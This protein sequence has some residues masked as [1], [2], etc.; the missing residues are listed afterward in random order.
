MLVAALSL[1]AQPASIR[2][3][4]P[5]L[6]EAGVPFFAITSPAS[7]G[8][9]SPPTDLQPLPDGRILAL[10]DRE[11]AVGDGT[12]WEVFSLAGDDTAPRSS[13]VA[14]AADGQIYTGILSGIA[15]LEFQA[16]GNLHRVPIAHTPNP[17]MLPTTAFKAG[18]RWYWYGGVGEVV[19]WKPD[20]TPSASGRISDLE[21]AFA[22]G[23]DIYL[24]DRSDGSFW[25][26]TSTGLQAIVSAGAT[27]A[28]HSVT[29]GIDLGGGNYIVGTNGHGLQHFEN[30]RLT[31]IRSG[32]PLAGLSRINDLCAA[33]DGLFAAA[34]DNLGIVFFDRQLRTVQVLDRALDHRL[35]RVRRIF[36]TRVGT[37]WGLLNDG[38]VCVEFPSRISNY[39]SM[40]STGLIFAQPYRFNGRLWL[41][42]DGQAQRGVYDADG[43]LLRFDVDTPPDEFLGALST[44]TGALLAGGRR[45]LYRR[46]AD[47]WRMVALA[48]DNPHLATAPDTEGRWAFVAQGVAGWLRPQGT[49]Y[50][51]ARWPAPQIGTLYGSICDARGVLWAEL[52]VARIARIE[53]AAGAPRIEV[54]GPE[55]GLAGGWAQLTVLEG[56]IRANVIGTVLRFDPATR[57]FEPDTGFHRTLPDSPSIVGRPN[58]DARGRLW[59]TTATGPHLFARQGAEYRPL[60]EPLRTGLLPLSITPDAGGPVWLHQRLQ[61]LRYDPDLPPPPRSDPRVVITRIHLANSNRTVFSPRGALPPLPFGDNS[62]VAHF[63][64]VDTSPAQTVTFEVR[65]L[66]T[67]DNWITN[68]VV[69]TIA[70]NRL[71][72]GSYTLQVRPV[73]QGVAGAMTQ[74]ALTIEPP[75]FRTPTAYAAYT[76]G[77]LA[78]IAFVAWYASWRERR[79]KAE[80][81]RLVALRTKELNDA[82]RQLAGNMQATLRQAAALRASEERYRQLSTELERRIAERTDAL[83]RTNDQLAASNQELES[84]SYS[85]SHDLRAPLRNINGFVDLLRRRNRDNLDSESQRFFQI[86]STET[87]RLSQLIDSLLTFARLSRSDF[88]C[89]RVAIAALVPQVIAELRPEYEHRPVEWKVGPLPTVAADPALLRQVVANLLSNAVKFTRHRQ[90][91]IIEIGSQPPDGEHPGEHVVF[92]RDNGAGFDPKYSAKLFG[93][94]QRLH[95]S[96]DFEGTGIGLANAKRIVLRHGGR[97]WATGTPGAGATFYFSLPAQP[98]APAAPASPPPV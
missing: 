77:T 67:G 38:I 47:T 25:R 27:N 98:A 71:K 30:G 88:K 59:L 94:F 31:P 58:I 52:G 56:E 55:S 14:I 64:A 36:A 82:N 21:R 15:R 70:F 12:R 35:A 45:G 26:E 20:E 60:D 95:H 5:G 24:S 10:A 90:P 68:G 92:V 48:L 75:W 50:E 49:G 78:F 17:L 65:L 28:S 9:S 44:E 29:C 61:L 57:R 66:G 33:G 13:Q 40:V 96:R 87:I 46:D 6:N 4:T 16:D 19:R 86:I 42:G 2:P 51:I 79:K 23:G 53:L 3:A 93:V 62:L 72:E 43:R 91:A 41:I 85:I 11:L 83:V 80:L 54:F 84:F 63:L 74:L 18:D 73:I 8:L 34:I 39:E 7:L 37:V 76:V 81:A 22:L 89:E 1:G 32:G 69:G 97:I